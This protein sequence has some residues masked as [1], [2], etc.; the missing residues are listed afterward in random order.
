MLSDQPNKTSIE[1]TH[2]RQ[3]SSAVNLS[4]NKTDISQSHISQPISWF[5]MANLPNDKKQKIIRFIL[6]ILCLGFLAAGR[7]N[8]PNN[9]VPAIFDRLIN[10]LAGMNE[11]VLGH[12]RLR[13][14]LLIMCSLFMD[15]MFLTSGIY[16]ALNSKTSRLIVSTLIFYFIRA[17]IQQ[18]WYAPYPSGY[19]WE[20]PGWPSL[21][22]AYGK[23]SDFFFSGHVGF[24]TINACE[25][26][27]NK[28]PW[29]AGLLTLLGLYTSFVLL[30]FQVHFTIDIFG[31]LLCASW[32]FMVVDMYKEKIDG[33]F[34]M[35]FLAFKS[36]YM[37]IFRRN[38]N[39][40]DNRSDLLSTLQDKDETHVQIQA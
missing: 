17:G 4:T 7:A 25:W 32:V 21:V 16:W 12:P 9:D 15:V 37:K 14:T 36:V 31:G 33:F 2:G 20:Y 22:V 19:Y 34:I 6:F 26:V 13:D 5:D 35:I 27:K 39:S 29:A 11:Y 8:I 30:L 23:S 18:L 3:Q 10:A 28:K 40:V 1:F 38:R 24:I